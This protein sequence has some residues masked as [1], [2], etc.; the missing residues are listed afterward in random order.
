MKAVQFK[1]FGGPEVLEVV[2][3]PSPD[4]TSAMAVVRVKSA[5]INPSDVKNIAGVFHQTTLPRIPGRDY[6]G[7]VEQGP[8][9][10]IGAEVW[11][12]GDI[13]YSKD[14]THAELL[15]VPIESLSRKPGSLSFDEAA[16]V[17]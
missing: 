5:S 1:T 12:T 4:A 11:G 9:D 6:A 15:L 17:G 7:V 16:T 8:E 14:G 10:W 2:E 3:L 13:G